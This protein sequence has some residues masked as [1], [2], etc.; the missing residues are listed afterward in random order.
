VSLILK[1]QYLRQWKLLAW[2]LWGVYSIYLRTHLLIPSRSCFPVTKFIPRRNEYLPSWFCK[3][4]WPR[5]TSDHVIHPSVLTDWFIVPISVRPKPVAYIIF[6]TFSPCVFHRSKRTL[7]LHA[8][9]RKSYIQWPKLTKP[10]SF[11]YLPP[12][13]FIIGSTRKIGQTHGFS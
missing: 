11:K 12:S 2:W 6:W 4:W 8:N 1:I 7:I 10:Y 5:I 3:T 13:I 9:K